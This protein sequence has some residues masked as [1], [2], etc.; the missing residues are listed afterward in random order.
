MTKATKWLWAQWRLR[1][2]WASAQS[3]QS[4]PSLIRVFAVHSKCS[5]GFNVSS[6][7]LRRLW[8]DWADAQAD[9]SLHWAHMPFFWFCHEVAHLK[10]F[11]MKH[12]PCFKIFPCQTTRKSNA[13]ADAQADLSLHWAHMPFFWFCH[14]VAHLKQ[15]LMKHKP[16]FK[17]FPCQ[18]T[19]RSKIETQYRYTKFLLWFYQLDKMIE[20]CNYFSHTF[21]RNKE[22]NSIFQLLPYI[23]VLPKFLDSQIWA[24][25][26]NPD[27]TAP[28]G[29]K[30]DQ[31]LHGFP[32]HLHLLDALHYR[33]SI[34]VK[35]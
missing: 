29:A 31:G 21:P 12:K 17:I 33:K 6:C 4:S 20:F 15:F 8:S 2:A 1:S 28:T 16:C 22:I 32:F 13:H 18:T 14:E 23:M 34:L 9:L 27:H 24:N 3:D 25:S 35:F 19:R 26:V 11:L 10:Q 5:W 7:G 30:S